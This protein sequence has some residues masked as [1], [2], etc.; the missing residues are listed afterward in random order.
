[1]LHRAR[2]L[3]VAALVLLA[4]GGRAFA[5][6]GPSPSAVS[7]ST[8]KLPDKPAS[9]R[10]LSDAASVDVFSGQVSYSVP[11]DLPAGPAGFGPNLSLVYAGELG[12]G[13]LG[14]GWSLG[15]I[16]L[17]RSLRQ[18]V[19]TYSDADEL[20]LVGIEGGGRLVR[21]PGFNPDHPLF[22]VEGHGRRI[23]VE[24]KG[25]R[26][27]VTDANGT[28]YHLGTSE[29]SREHDPDDVTRVLAWRAAL[30]VNLTGQAIELSYGRQG[31]QLYLEE[32]R[33][34]AEALDG[35]GVLIALPDPKYRAL[36][37]YDDARYDE[38]VSFRSGYEVRTGRRLKQVQ[39]LAF[40]AS[41][42]TFQ[43]TYD[44]ETA[45]AQQ[46]QPFTLSR[47]SG[48]AMKGLAGA[49]TLPPLAFRYV[50]PTAP[51]KVELAGLDAWVLNQR[52]VSLADVDGDGMQDLLRLEAGNHQWKQNLGGHFGP[53]RALGGAADVDMAV[54][55]LIDLDGDARPE[56]VRVVDDTWRRYTLDGETWQPRGPWA[57]TSGLALFGPDSILC[58]ING[59]G[60][61]D[62]VRGSADA[63]YVSFGG[64]SGIGPAKRLP[65][66][67]PVDATVEPGRR[68]V[69]FVDV[70]GDGLADVVWLTDE[71]MKVFLGRGDGTFVPWSRVFYPWGAGAFDVDDVDLSDLD[72]DGL[73][74]L[75]RYTAAN[76][77]W[78]RGE[79]R[80]R[81]EPTGRHIQ[82]PEAAPFDAVVTVADVLGTGSQQVI[83][84]SP[85]G[86][87][88]LDLAGT[89]S[90]GMLSA[91]D[92]GLGKTTS[93]AYT[94]SALLAVAAADAGNPWA[95][96]LPVNTPLPSSLQVSPGY[97]G[98]IRTL[99]Y[100]VR[101]GFWDAS[102]RRFGGFLESK[103]ITV[104]D[105]PIES[106]VEYTRFHAGLGDERILRG[107][108]WFHRS[109]NGRGELLNIVR[110]DCAALPAANLTDPLSRLA[111]VKET[112]EYVYEGGPT[113]VE[114][115]TRFDHDQD[116]RIVAEHHEGRLDLL[117]GAQGPGDEREVRRTYE[118]DDTTWVR[119]KLCSETVYEGDG[120]GAISGPPVSQT[121]STYGDDHG[122]ATTPTSGNCRVGRGWLRR[123]EGL[124]AARAAGETDRWI[125]LRALT[126][127][128]L[129]NTIRTVESGVQRDVALAADAALGIPAGFFGATET[130]HPTATSSLTWTMKWD[131]QRGLP[132]EITDPNGITSTATY[133]PLGRQTDVSV[134]GSP[135][136]MRFVYEWESSP[137]RTRTFL[138]DRKASEVPAAVGGAGSGW[139][140]TVAF[141]DGAT[142]P[143]YSATRAAPDKWI[144]SGWRQ[145]DSR[146]SVSALAD[147]FYFS[148][149]ADPIIMAP[150]ALPDFHLQ[151]R[152]Y[153]A[154][155]RL[156]A[157]T[158]PNTAR[159]T[160]RYAPFEQTAT[161]SDVAPLL[162]RMD[163]LARVVH[164]E[165]TVAGVVERTD[166]RHD[167][168]GRLV[169]M[170]LQNGLAS[171]RF[172]YDTLGR[173]VH[174]EDPDTGP[175]DLAYD[176]RNLLVRHR[177]GDG[178]VLAYFYDLTA[179]LI[180]RGPR[181]DFDHPA[182]D[183]DSAQQ[184]LGKGT[185][186]VYH[187]DDPKP[188]ASAG[189]YLKSRLAWVEEPPGTG[190]DAWTALFRYDAFGHASLIARDL[191][192]IKGWETTEQSP[193]GLVLRREAGDGFLLQPAYDP[194]ARLV[195][196]GNIWRAGQM[197]AGDGLGGLDASG[198]TLNETYG[199][200][201]V[202]TYGRDAL[203]LPA[204]NAL[205]RPGLPTPLY[206]VTITRN[207]YGAPLTVASSGGGA[208]DHTASYAYDDGTR[209]IDATL[210]STDAN[211]WKFRY[212]YDG[213]QNMISRSQQGPSTRP[214][215]I[216]IISGYYRYGEN[217]KGPRQLTSIVHKDCPG[218]LTTFS[219]DG[220]GR[221]KT[222]DD[223]RLTYDGYDQLQRVEKP[224][225][226]TLVS[227]AYG[228]DGLRT[229]TSGAN[230]NK[231]HWFTEQH[232]RSDTL[233]NGLRKVERWHY[234]SVGDRLV[235]RL[236]F[237]DTTT[238]PPP[239]AAGTS[240]SLPTLPPLSVALRGT[241]IASSLLLW[242]LAFLARRRTV[243]AAVAAVT[244]CAV[245][246]A[247]LG[248]A[249]EQKLQALQEDAAH[250][251]YF[252]QG[253]EAGPTLTSDAGGTVLDDRRFEP[254]G[255]PI[256]GDLH[257]DAFNILNKET[258]EETG[259]SYHGA[260]WMAPQTG[261]WLTPDPAIKGSVG[262]GAMAA[263]LHPY[264]YVRQSPTLYTDPDGA[265]T[266]GGGGRGRA[267]G[268]RGRGS[269]EAFIL[270]EWPELPKPPEEFRRTPESEYEYNKG[271]EEEE[272]CPGCKVENLRSGNGPRA[273]YQVPI[274]V[275][276]IIRPYWEFNVKPNVGDI[277]EGHEIWQF[278]QISMFGLS[279]GR[280]TGLVSRF[281]PAFALTRAEH[282]SVYRMQVEAKLNRPETLRSMTP[283]QLIEKNAEILAQVR[284]PLEA[285]AAKRQA[286]E[287]ARQWVNLDQLPPQTPVPQNPVPAM[288]PLMQQSP[289]EP[290]PTIGPR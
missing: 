246:L 38:V 185:D 275:G 51:A 204:S 216:P 279:P 245:A 60:R 65:R 71:W 78:Y 187:Y 1:M 268:G 63:V 16:S 135:K 40:G 207:L 10:G 234:V 270:Y 70:N 177:N 12:N 35:A 113:A 112:H 152:H 180:A 83:W 41:P 248:C 15:A 31:N 89:G 195:Q 197:A 244:A 88:A 52:D 166:A 105:S 262:A 165:Q 193:S 143:L 283:R 233:Q 67:S 188:D 286:L 101:D 211:R 230:A 218:D 47:I 274:V 62:V 24:Q 203:G 104:G 154:L 285:W 210:G 136:F 266:R 172:A 48:V 162:T 209:L 34:G 49:G 156:D 236:T 17:S 231:Q 13:S 220:A 39:V 150:P 138:W 247:P 250:R 130:V 121:R 181:S 191:G 81:F 252:H 184:L 45:A 140:E 273:R 145:Y 212:R 29:A 106:L 42:R 82:R 272:E 85:R 171:H 223:K 238:W 190:T 269:E 64:P 133:D 30:I 120:H 144:V 213:L 206:A 119:D 100:G 59:D 79:A 92:N 33:W 139:R 90:Q 205:T 93:F 168:A 129:G 114:T 255:Q 249:T 124:L 153:D 159:K 123:S 232:T 50:Q 44:D 174:T 146:G 77:L 277:Y 66:I 217:N 148:G 76:V 91:I 151:T 11:L 199:N 196:L 235:A 251:I 161:S 8:L 131:P 9:V 75:V 257:R 98:A 5:L 87:W 176:D 276:G 224:A 222:E 54:G 229:Y 23:K 127:D 117:P 58:D 260:R 178:Q 27:E 164:T 84:S 182:L 26:F 2:L 22:Y 267:R 284:T 242:L 194:A 254:F 28:K 96:K 107:K 173:L 200:T 147:A 157:Q 18:G 32:L 149:S 241:L 25:S 259:W 73:V 170:D 158:L 122:D 128:A 221:L 109:D 167:A 111:V 6:S 208:I 19:P 243:R 202:Q 261:R 271:P 155:G 163:G 125:T 103:Q 141:V 186:Y 240:W 61:T 116:A 265:Q 99:L 69:R 160:I 289:I 55:R 7:A 142:E 282:A 102:E 215:G 95:Q 263:D 74:D 14:V 256:D 132:T 36:L 281:N 137:P 56:L 278:A 198:R 4:P 110:N 192:G 108:A 53:P 94:T 228:H 134:T 237:A 189:G 118:S 37:T 72:R 225:G 175:R 179:R 46:R 86:M 201:L 280:G 57:G 80:L 258:N 219:Y 183:Y 214:N 3:P 68:E 169:R 288:I 227:H 43:L 21:A 239:V 287:F 115:R 97:G 126:Y 20:D 264:A 253:A 290:P 226:T